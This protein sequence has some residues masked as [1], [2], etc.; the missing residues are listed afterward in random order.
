MGCSLCADAWSVGRV[1][2]QGHI[3]NSGGLKVAAH[4]MFRVC[5]G[6]KSVSLACACAAAQSSFEMGNLSRKGGQ[7]GCAV[8]QG[9]ALL[10]HL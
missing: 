4:G 7:S 10:E 1:S 2:T 3:E 9:G 6:S 5:R 8:G